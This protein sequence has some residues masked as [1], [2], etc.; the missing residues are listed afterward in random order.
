MELGPAVLVVDDDAKNRSLIR[1]T[2]GGFCNVIEADSGPAALKTVKERPVEL[3]LLDVMMP[4]MN[5]YDVC[6]QMKEEARDYLPIVLVTGLGEQ[7]DRNR[8][9]ESGADDFL[10]KPVDRR[11]LLLRTRAFLRLREQDRVIRL[12]LGEVQALQAAK[13]DLMALLVHDLRSPLAGVIAHLQLLAEEVTGRAAADVQQ[14]MRGAE[15]ALARLEETLQIRLIEEGKLTVRREMV[16][17]GPLVRDSV[18]TLE[19][20]ARRKKVQLSQSVE[21]ESLASVDASLVRRSLENLVSNALKYTPGGTD[22]V[23]TVRAA[24]KYVAIEVADRGPGIPDDDKARMFEKFGSVEAKNGRQRKGIG[25]GLYLVKLVAEGH[26]GA[27]SVADR[28]GGGSVFRLTLG[29]G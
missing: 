20:V 6:K 8:G 5:G 9:L 16:A 27:V 7:E 12:Q 15:T 25:L 3:V 28:P 19:P 14:A 29:I 22:V 23:V 13:D 26:G 1:A 11:E 21:G 24:A 2:L 4:G 10:T 18:A 17:L